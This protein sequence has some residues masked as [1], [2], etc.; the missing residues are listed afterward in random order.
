M[1][2]PYPYNHVYIVVIFFLSLPKWVE[3]VEPQQF[4]CDPFSSVAV[5]PFSVPRILH[6]RLIYTFYDMQHAGQAAFY[7]FVLSAVLYYGKYTI[8]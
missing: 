1:S 2:F 6:T 3:K 5:R 7:T 4:T 8:T